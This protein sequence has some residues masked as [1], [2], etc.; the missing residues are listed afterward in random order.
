MKSLKDVATELGV[1]PKVVRGEIERGA[2]PAHKIGKKG[3]Y[4]ITDET[5]ADYKARTLVAPVAT[6]I[7]APRRSPRARSGEVRHLRALH[8]EARDA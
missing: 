2:L 5:V 1:T 4:R 7:R 6:P 3:V 8:A